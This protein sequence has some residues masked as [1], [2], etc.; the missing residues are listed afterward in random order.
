MADI[1]SKQIR[2]LE[3]LTN[4]KNTDY[5]AIDREG[6]STTN[7]AAL[8][9][10][11]VGL[12]SNDK[13]HYRTTCNFTQEKDEQLA[14]LV[15]D[16][17]MS[18][19]SEHPVEN[20]TIKKY[21]DDTFS[22]AQKVANMT[23]EI[24]DDNST[25]SYPSTQAVKE[26]L[27]KGGVYSKLALQFNGGYGQCTNPLIDKDNSMLVM[28]IKTGDNITTSQYVY[29]STTTRFMV[30]GGSL[31]CYIKGSATTNRVVVPVE[32]NTKYKIAFSNTGKVIV[33]DIEYAATPGTVK[34]VTFILGVNATAT[35]TNPFFGKYYSITTAD[36]EDIQGVYNGTNTTDITHKYTLDSLDLDGIEQGQ[37]VW[38]DIVGTEDIILYPN[39]KVIRANVV[40]NYKKIEV[41][42]KKYLP[43][44]PSTPVLLG[45]INITQPT[46]FVSFDIP[47][48]EIEK[49]KKIWI[50]GTIKSND[51]TSSNQRLLLTTGGGSPLTSVSGTFFKGL[52]YLSAFLEAMPNK[53]YLSEIT[54]STYNY[55][56]GTTGKATGKIMYDHLINFGLK[57]DTPSG[58]MV[59]N[60]TQLEVWG[61]DNSSNIDLSQYVN[62]D[63]PIQ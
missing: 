1:L 40:E 18:D 6:T 13:T 31:H 55:V 26:A 35:K 54:A 57:F 46:S 59:D 15:L 29:R 4:V 32:P 50:W 21:V 42:E 63:D 27:E 19:F 44:V 23:D 36:T 30:T 7:K 52:A 37:R 10:I 45:T 47:N 25:D 56:A 43:N 3:N 61:I 53:V 9:D 22:Q 5:L 58:T 48:A 41:I 62:L 33:D 12:F 60:G 51:S 39:Y 2:D 38:K 24:Y 8:K 49:W 34:Y 28:E 17:S 14:N 11:D 16:D 20:K